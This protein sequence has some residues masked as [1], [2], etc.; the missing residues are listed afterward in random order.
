MF[1]EALMQ[2]LVALRN[3]GFKIINC[4]HVIPPA[5]FTPDWHE[6]PEIDAG[7]LQKYNIKYD[8]NA[9]MFYLV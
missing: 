5:R 4:E 1:N 2:Y 9:G 6:F 8:R 3:E 7:L